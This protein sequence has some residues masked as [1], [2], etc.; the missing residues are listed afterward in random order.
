MASKVGLR[1]PG[2]LGNH[3][4]L[5]TDSKHLASKTEKENEI[6]IGSNI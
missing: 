5:E 4:L 6:Q 2:S 3:S 1:K